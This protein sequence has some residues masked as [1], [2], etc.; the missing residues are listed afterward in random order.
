MEKNDAIIHKTLERLGLFLTNA[1]LNLNVFAT[2]L[3]DSA[4]QII[5]C[6]DSL[7]PAGTSFFVD[8]VVMSG[9]KIIRETFE[10]SLVEAVLIEVNDAAI[11]VSRENVR[12]LVHE[13]LKEMLQAAKTKVAGLKDEFSIKRVAQNLV[14]L[15]KASLVE[16]KI[17]SIEQLLQMFPSFNTGLNSSTEPS[18]HE[19]ACLVE[20]HHLTNCAVSLFGPNC[21]GF[22]EKNV[23]L[24]TEHHLPVA[25]NKFSS[26]G[27]APT[28]G[29]KRREAIFLSCNPGYQRKAKKLK[30]EH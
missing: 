29:Y 27:G 15:L 18:T 21:K 3:R 17:K 1:T 12:Q 25:G 6:I 9:N 7:E 5:D 11:Q 20:Y 10:Q 23:V 14:L 19:L 22:V 2:K 8:K 26:G 13:K 28:A 16:S 30:V 24:L 4:Q